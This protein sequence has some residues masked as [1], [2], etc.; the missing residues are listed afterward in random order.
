[1]CVSSWFSYLCNSFMFLLCRHQ[2]W[3]YLNNVIKSN[4]LSMFWFCFAVWHCALIILIYYFVRLITIIIINIILYPLDFVWIVCFR[5][6][7]IILLLLWF[8]WFA[9]DK[10]MALCIRKQYALTNIVPKSLV[11]YLHYVPWLYIIYQPVFNF[12]NCV[13]LTSIVESYNRIALSCN[14]S[15]NHIKNAFHL[16]FVWTINSISLLWIIVVSS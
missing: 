15:L 12:P 2:S 4:N 16:V 1:M 5:W 6:W 10:A 3:L 9:H 13:C 8:A 7:I 14:I 11:K